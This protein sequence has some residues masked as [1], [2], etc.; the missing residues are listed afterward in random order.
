[1]PLLGVTNA[2]SFGVTNV[3][4]LSL[5]GIISVHL[6]GVRRAE[7]LVLHCQESRDPVRLF[8]YVSLKLGVRVLWFNA[9]V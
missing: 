1:M 8:F 2:Y 6:L 5:L 9:A 4:L 3:H 7:N